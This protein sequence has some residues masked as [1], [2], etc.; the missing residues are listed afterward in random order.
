M[1]KNSLRL[2]TLLITG[3]TI[4]SL[5]IVFYQISSLVLLESFSRLEERQ[6]RNTLA[7]VRATLDDQVT[8]LRN[9]TQDY[10]WWGETYAFMQ[11]PNQEYKQAYLTPLNLENLD[12]DLIIL[13]DTDER[14][15]FAGTLEP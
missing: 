3:L 14:V 1:K 9:W 5:C 7:R 2:R 8:R 6:M 11:Q 13:L 12:L 4:L 15:V 10:A